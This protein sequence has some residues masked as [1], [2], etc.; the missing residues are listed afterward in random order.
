MQIQRWV[1]DE[2]V[3]I[4]LPDVHDHGALIYAIDVDVKVDALTK[5]AAQFERG[6]VEVRWEVSGNAGR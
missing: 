3:I 4:M 1:L 6:G 5:L 2:F